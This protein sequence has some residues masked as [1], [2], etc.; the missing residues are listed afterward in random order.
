MECPGHVAVGRFRTS[1]RL[2]ERQH[3]QVSN[4]LGWGGF[5]CI[6]LGVWHAAG[7]NY[8]SRW[9]AVDAVV[10]SLQIAGIE[11]NYNKTDLRYHRETRRDRIYF[12]YSY[13]VGEKEYRSSCYYWLG[14]TPPDRVLW[15]NY[16]VG[17]HFTARYKPSNPSVAV[18]EPGKPLYGLFVAGLVC[19]LLSIVG[20]IGTKETQWQRKHP[21][22][23]HH[24]RRNS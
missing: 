12:E 1:K 13:S 16:R 14:F 21:P 15:N 10:T 8:C 5:V 2:F 23:L 20:R 9:P 7:M 18:V 3:A 19:I 17:W 11:T 6:L 24:H 22:A 4:G